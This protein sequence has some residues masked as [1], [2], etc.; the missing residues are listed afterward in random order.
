MTTFP[1][2]VERWRG[3]ATQ[4]ASDVL[5][6]NPQYNASIDASGLTIDTLVDTLLALIQKESSGDPNASG[7]SGNSIGLM[8]LNYGI[9]TP[10]QLGYTG[11]SEG[12]K[13]P[14][15][16]IFWGCKYFLYQLDRY[17][18]LDKAIAAYNAGSYITNDAGSLINQSYLDQV[19]SY[20]GEKK[21]SSS[22][23][24]Q[25]SDSGGLLGKIKTAD[26][27]AQEIHNEEMKKAFDVPGPPDEVDT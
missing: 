5:A 23:D 14:Y 10:Q 19:L 27:I 17:S 9:G 12:L 18:D 26:E 21:T 15:T 16:N 3:T 13:D 2:N 6:Q 20:L 7:D 4:A 1:D 8:Q 25:P 22:P 24:S 11:T